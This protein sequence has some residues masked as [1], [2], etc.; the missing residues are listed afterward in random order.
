LPVQGHSVLES[1]QAKAR[2]YSLHMLGDIP[3]ML[4]DMMSVHSTMYIGIQMSSLY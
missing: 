3:R 4:G 1:P 2:K